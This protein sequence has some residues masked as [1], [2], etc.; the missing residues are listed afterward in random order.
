MPT[1]HALTE[2]SAQAINFL[3]PQLQIMEAASSVLTI[4]R[5]QNE[6]IWNTAY[7]CSDLNA[8]NDLMHKYKCHMES[9]MKRSSNSK[10]GFIVWLKLEGNPPLQAVKCKA[11][12]PRNSHNICERL[13]SVGR[14]LLDPGDN[15]FNR[16]YT[17]HFNFDEV[18]LSKLEKQYAEALS[19]DPMQWTR[20]VLE[21]DDWHAMPFN[22]LQDVNPEVSSTMFTNTI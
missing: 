18:R 10:S 21:N 13:R 9:A 22:K 20:K 17:S 11:I 7:G 5:M 2:D 6:E 4:Q 8:S 16:N 3:R 1:V 14:R 12:I 15:R 19:V